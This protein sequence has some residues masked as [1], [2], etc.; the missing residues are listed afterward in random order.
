MMKMYSIV[1]DICSIVI[2]PNSEYFI[3]KTKKNRTRHLC[4]NCKQ[5][6]TL[7]KTGGDNATVSKTE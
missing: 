1:C 2:D 3:R 7:P 4:Q 6:D 5:K